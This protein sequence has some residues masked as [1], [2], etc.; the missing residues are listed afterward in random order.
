MAADG[1][2]LFARGVGPLYRISA[3][4]GAPVPLT[5]LHSGETNHRQMK[6]AIS[7]ST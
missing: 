2:I 5:H 3:T 1:T 4:G 6:P 7:R